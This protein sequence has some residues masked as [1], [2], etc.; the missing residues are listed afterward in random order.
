MLTTLDSPPLSPAARQAV[1]AT[2][3]VEDVLLELKSL[4]RR[5]NRQLILRDL[6]ALLVS[7]DEVVQSSIDAPN[8]LD[9]LAQAATLARQSGETITGHSLSDRAQR[10][11]ERLLGVA[12]ALDHAREATIDVIVS[13]QGEVIARHG[14]VARRASETLPEPRPL[15]ISHGAPVLHAFERPPLRAEVD[16]SPEAF[17]YE[18]DEQPEDIDEVEDVDGEPGIRELFAED[19]E[20]EPRLAPEDAHRRLDL[21]VEVDATADPALAAGLEGELAQL[22]SLARSCLEDVAAN[23]NLR[24]LTDDERFVWQAQRGFESRLCASVDAF[25]GLGTAFYMASGNGAR[26]RGLDIVQMALD[27]GRDG[28]TIDP[29]RA[30]ARTFAIASIEGRD[31]I[32]AAIL[33]LKQSQP[34]SYAAQGR[35][36]AMA[37][38]PEVVPAL[39]KLLGDDDPRLVETALDALHHRGTLRAAAVVDLLEHPR[40]AVRG[41]AA[42]CLAHADARDGAV[43]LLLETLDVEDDEEVLLDVAEALAALGHGAGLARVRELVEECVEEPASLP[44][45]I[46]VRCMQL[47]GVAGR[48][49]DAPLLRALYGGTA[50]EATALGFHGHPLLI[51]ALHE[52]L[53]GPAGSI[54]VGPTGA[55]EAARAL[56]RITGAPL[57]D[58][59]DFYD[60]VTDHRRVEAWLTEHR[61]QF[62]DDLRYRFGQPWHGLTVVAELERDEVPMALRRLCAFELGLLLR[63]RPIQVT[64]FAAHQAERIAAARASITAADGDPR[65]SPGIW[66][67]LEG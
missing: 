65:L 19:D 35:A 43:D 48:L 54:I 25:V 22:R 51:D 6:Q 3:V 9:L 67:R 60:P 28:L 18:P 10:M 31:T 17:T 4:N 15:E 2:E 63:E 12:R 50:G 47:L 13:R 59:R 52:A 11:N 14:D 20:E 33:A 62:R 27:H 39:E 66:L 21:L 53:R 1:V 16:V 44:E 42:R 49:S 40:P 46:R 24:R 8:H 38:N 61:D 36:L 41:K 57:H 26:C 64:D 29:F 23:A 56:Q 37:P 7:L 34:Y 5:V 58:A 45:K 30:F 32:R 55:R